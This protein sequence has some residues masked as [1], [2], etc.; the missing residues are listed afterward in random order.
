MNIPVSHTINVRRG[1]LVV[2]MEVP[3]HVAQAAESDDLRREMVSA[4]PDVEPYLARM[5]QHKEAGVVKWFDDKKGYGFLMT[6][7]G[8]LFVHWRGIAGDG[9]KNLEQGQHVRFFR[10]PSVVDER[11]VEAVEVEIIRPYAVP[12]LS[13][14]TSG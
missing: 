12:D 13:G 4:F 1:M 6:D 8:D 3:I 9:Y 10:R 14:T 2:S 5:R 11:G 7:S